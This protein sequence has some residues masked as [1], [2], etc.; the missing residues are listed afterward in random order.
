MDTIHFFSWS[1]IS[2]HNPKGL[3]GMG[4]LNNNTQQSRE[5]TLSS[6]VNPQKRPDTMLRILIRGKDQK[7]EQVYPFVDVH[8]QCW[9]ILW[10][11][12]SVG[13]AAVFTDRNLEPKQFRN[14]F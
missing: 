6:Q 7:S 14:N 10:E 9:V 2:L 11:K 8:S 12:V 13:T 1:Y 3:S 4:P 5:D